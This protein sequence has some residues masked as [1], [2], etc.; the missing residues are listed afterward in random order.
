MRPDK[1]SG[2]VCM[3]TGYNAATDELCISDSWGPGFEERWI[4][5]EEAQAVS[6]HN[7]YVIGL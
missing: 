2:H 3:I 4:T 5:P 1:E 7:F 6:Q